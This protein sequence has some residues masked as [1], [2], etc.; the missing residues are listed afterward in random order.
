MADAEEFTS[1][2]ILPRNDGERL[3]LD[4]F[5]KGEYRPESSSASAPSPKPLPRAR[6]RNGSSLT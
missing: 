1:V 5:A 6:K 3:Y 2:Y 4:L